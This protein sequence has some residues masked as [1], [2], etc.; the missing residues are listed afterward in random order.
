MSVMCILILVGNSAV[1]TLRI[2]FEISNF[3]LK[4][5]SSVKIDRKNIQSKLQLNSLQPVFK[6]SPV[7][8][9][10]TSRGRGST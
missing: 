6:N 3:G 5:Q 7:N 9:S 1:P 10:K 4:K 8:D 2:F